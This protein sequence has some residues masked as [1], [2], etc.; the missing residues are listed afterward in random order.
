[1]RGEYFAKI[2]EV[3]RYIGFIKSG[4]M[5]YAVYS[6][7]G[8]EHVVGLEF[9]GE[10]VS[11]FPFSLSQESSRVS[12][13]AMTPCEV[14]C[15]EVKDVAKKMLEDNN[16]KDIVMCSTEAVFSTVYDRYISLYCKTPQER[17]NELISH[18]PDIFNQFPLKDIASFLNITPI[19]L[20]RLR[21][22]VFK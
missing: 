2:G 22:N 12:I 17:Y 14:Y 10:F 7:D 6:A 15:V 8:T 3:A 11:D 19:H 13:I 1:M 21:K 4:A 5:K 16:V 20:S 18:H 9:A